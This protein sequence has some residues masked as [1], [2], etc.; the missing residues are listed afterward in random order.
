MSRE[1]TLEHLSA[2]LPWGLEFISEL[3]KPYDEYGKQPNWTL[4]GITEMFGDKCLMTLESSD[5]YP[6]HL[7][8]PILRPLSDLTKEIEVNGEKF[9]PILEWCDI[10][11]TITVFSIGYERKNYF[12]KFAFD[13]EIV[14][15]KIPSDADSMNYY[16]IK[17]LLSWHFDVFGLIESGN[18]IDKN[19][20]T[21]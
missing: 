8:K 9:V 2:Y 13:S 21:K 4:N 17:K 20:L 14:T 1:I 18:A 12:A 10:P 5:A 11:D 16:T 7:C 19:T 3:D 15:Y 6:I